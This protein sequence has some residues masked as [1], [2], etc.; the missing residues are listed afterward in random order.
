MIYGRQKKRRG[1]A[2][3]VISG[4]VFYKTFRFI[5][6]VNQP[7]NIMTIRIMIKRFVESLLL[8]REFNLNLGAVW[9]FVGFSTDEIF[10]E[11]PRKWRSNY[12]WSGKLLLAIRALVSYSSAPLS[13][14]AILGYVFSGIAFLL[15]LYWILQFLFTGSE[16][17]FTTIAVSIWLLG[18]FTSLTV[19]TLALYAGSIYDEVKKRPHSVIRQISGK[20]R[21]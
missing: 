10:I 4:I 14:L 3:E 5:T 18:G 9:S 2:L 15:S 13:V 8:F 7:D 17:G 11:K 6:G 1:G 19:A 20:T 16:S 21:L 12:N